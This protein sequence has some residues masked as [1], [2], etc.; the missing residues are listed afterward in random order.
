MPLDGR[1]LGAA[2][3]RLA[4]EAR[5]ARRRSARRA[6]RTTGAWRATRCP[7]WRA[8]C[9]ELEQPPPPGLDRL[10]PL[11]DGFE[12]L[13]EAPLPAD[14]TA[15][16]RA[17]QQQGVN[18]LAFLRGAGPGRRAR[19][20]HGP[21]QDAAGDV[22]VRRRAGTHAGRLPDQRALQLGGRAGALPS[23]RC[24]SPSTTAPGRALDATRRRHADQLRDPAPR[25]ERA[26]GADAGDAVVLDEA[27]AI[28]NPDSQTARAAYALPAG[29]PPGADRHAGREPPRRAVEPDALREPRPA[30]RARRLR[31]ALRAP[32]RRRAARARPRRCASASA[33]SC[34]A[35]CKRD[36][37]PEL[38]PRTDAVLRVELDDGERAVYDAVRAATQKRRARAARRRGRR[39]DGG[40][41]GAAAPAPG[42]L[43]PGAG[44]RARRAPTSSKVEALLEALETAVADGHKALVFSQWTCLLDLIEPA[45][46]R[47]EL[48]FARLDGTTRDR[49]E[50]VDALPGGRRPAGDAGLAQGRRHRP[51]P[52]RRRSRLPVRPV[53]EPRRRGAGRRPRPPHRPGRG[54]CSSTAWSPPTPSRSASSRCRTKRALMDAALGDAAGA[55]GLTR[56]DLLALLA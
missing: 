32:D 5:P 4:A 14:L 51:Q 46:A 56:D 25:R 28:K 44:A 50:V 3:G 37:A 24:A 45:L 27:Q 1:R 26:G 11:V 47:A 54:R 43:P 30:R 13:P 20:R 12:R 23:R 49:G 40:A 41:R 55:A 48:P 18:W 19:R 10:A 7:R 38:P 16:L 53:V 21:R 2:A 35:A 6:R 52:D 42:R 15:T 9:D 17:Y 33:R 29:V 34:C 36:V 8:L 22:R 39:R 31:R